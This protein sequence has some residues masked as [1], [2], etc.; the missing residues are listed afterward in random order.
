MN[1]GNETLG[2]SNV[3]NTSVGAKFSGNWVFEL[4]L[5]TVL[6]AKSLT[7]STPGVKILSF[8]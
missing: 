1:D 2:R 5:V 8:R 3:S 4:S 6:L 7:K